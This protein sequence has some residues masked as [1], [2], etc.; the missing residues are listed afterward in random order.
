TAKVAKEVAEGT[1]DASLFLFLTEGMEDTEGTLRLVFF[2]TRT[3][4][5]TG[6]LNGFAL[7][8]ADLSGF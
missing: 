6:R 2:G 4:L 7:Q 3:C 8:N 1:E 5:P